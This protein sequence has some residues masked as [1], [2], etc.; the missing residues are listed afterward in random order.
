MVFEGGLRMGRAVDIR[1]ASIYSIIIN[2]VQIIAV[3]AIAGLTIFTDIITANERF[4]HIVVIV[5]A[6]LA[7]WGAGVDIV[8]ALST[9]RIQVQSG[10][11]REAYR[12]LEDLNNTLR[13][14]RHDFTNHLQVVGSLIEMGE[15]Q[16]AAA[17]IDRIYGDVNVVGNALR[18][19]SPAVNAL[20]KIKLAESEK[21]GVSTEL[22]IKSNWA[23]LSAKGWEMCR[24]LGNLI[25]NALDA[26]QKTPE[27]YLYIALSEDERNYRFV[28]ENNGPMIPDEIGLR[29]F[30]P[31][32]TTKGSERGMGLAI[33][34]EILTEHGGGIVM[35]SD[36]M[37]T[38]FE[39]WIKRASNAPELPPP[40]PQG[41]NPRGRRGQ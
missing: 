13:A 19:A 18:T 28:V 34:Q 12:Q 39:G 1:K 29:I 10:M 38:T 41:H 5:A 25:D 26:L 15:Y 3:L 23:D 4:V 33:V 36:R 37:R 35:R 6:L 14:Q 22:S 8:Q 16:E 24:V 7:V 9:R 20:L 40:S 30:Q 21:R 2:I 11:L 31:G 32:F 27:P 17:Y